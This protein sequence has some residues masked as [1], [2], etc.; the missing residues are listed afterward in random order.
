VN[1]IYGA[2]WFS[3]SIGALLFLF[4]TWFVSKIEARELAKLPLIGKY[5]AVAK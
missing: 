1:F 4:F 2:L 5:F 3:I